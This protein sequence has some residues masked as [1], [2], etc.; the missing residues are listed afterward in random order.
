MSGE[1]GERG[2]KLIFINSQARVKR[3]TQQQQHF[4]Y[5]YAAHLWRVEKKVKNSLLKIFEIKTQMI[6]LYLWETL[7]W[8][9]VKTSWRNK[10]SALR[11]CVYTFTVGKKHT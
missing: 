5:C 11:L 10:L 8:I 2:V 6:R 9:L 1:K 7:V 4:F 3:Q